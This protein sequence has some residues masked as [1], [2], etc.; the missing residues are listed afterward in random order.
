MPR[1]S[2]RSY[3]LSGIPVS[4]RSSIGKVHPRTGHEGPY[5]EQTY[6]STISLTSTPFG[7]WWSAL[8]PGRF[9]RRKETLYPFRRRMGGPQNRSG[10]VR[11]M[12]PPPGFDPRTVQPI[13]S[14]CIDYSM[15]AHFRLSKLTDNKLSWKTRNTGKILNDEGLKPCVITWRL[16]WQ[17]RACHSLLFSLRSVFIR[18][19]TNLPQ[20]LLSR[21]YATNFKP[22][23]HKFNIIMS[24]TIFSSNYE[25][26]MELILQNL[27]IYLCS[28]STVFLPS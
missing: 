15:P 6:S 9:N 21:N 23:K 19:L 2:I 11:R 24:G 26:L 18:Q 7:S 12:S 27:E 13:A 16:L 22:G 17:L 1:S 5:G 28:K 10:R 3:L 20:M 25:I 4:L 8:S 14:R